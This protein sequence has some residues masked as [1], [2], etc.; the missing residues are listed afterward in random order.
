MCYGKRRSRLDAVY[1]VPFHH[2]STTAETAPGAG[3]SAGLRVATILRPALPATAL[4][5]IQTAALGSRRLSTEI[6]CMVGVQPAFRNGNFTARLDAFGL[7]SCACQN[8]L[9][10]AFTPERCFRT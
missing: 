5:S 2:S 4:G 3:I 9:P 6:R 1:C 7:R 10:P 8:H